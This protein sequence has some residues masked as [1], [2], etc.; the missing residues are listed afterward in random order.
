MRRCPQP[1]V[2]AVDGACAGAGAILAMASD[3]RFGTERSKVAFLFVRVGL[4]G[5]DMGACAMLPRIVGLG[6]A[7]E[8]LYT[9]KAMPGRA[10]L[11]VGLL[12]TNSAIRR[13]CSRARGLRACA[14]DGPTLAHAMTK[15]CCTKSGRCRSTK[16]SMRKRARRRVHGERQDFRRAYEAFVAKRP[17]E[18]EGNCVGDSPGRSST[19]SIA[20]SSRAL[21][22]WLERR[23]VLDD[24]RRRRRELPRVGARAGRRRDSARL[25]SRPLRRIAGRA[26]RAHALPG[27][28]N[29]GTTLGACRLCLRD[30][31]SGQRADRAVRHAPNCS[32]AIFRASSPGGCIAAFALSEREAGSDVAAIATRAR[33]DGEAYVID[34]EKTWISN[35]G[36]ADFYVVFARTGAPGAKGLSAFVVDARRAGAIAGKRIETISPHPAGNGALRRLRVSR[37]RIASATEGDGFRDRD[38][39]ARRLSQH[40]RCGRARIRAARAS[41]RRSRTC[42]PARLFGAPLAR[43]A[44]DASRDRRDGD[45]RRRE[46]AAGL[47][48]GVDEGRRRRR[49]SRAKPRWRSGLRPRRPGASAIAPC[50]SSVGAASR[51]ARSSSDSTATFARCESTKARARFS[52][53]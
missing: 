40:G 6:R 51:A 44:T 20:R 42:A 15:R 5:C 45:R 52:S 9:G 3:L 26:R 35:A 41:T 30:A 7:A 16:R 29:A 28:R 1:I 17:P 24:E 25:R 4:A 10:R 48:R 47:P 2:A 23:D 22:T 8:M 11:S 33:R 46:R 27:A 53:S 31:G 12:S 21:E 37:S 18:F 39:D 38:G 49:A 19:K 14:C 36:L 32:A 50:S 34:G 43:T 13:A